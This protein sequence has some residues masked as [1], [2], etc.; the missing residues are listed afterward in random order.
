MP[1]TT[2]PAILPPSPRE[3]SE[4]WGGVGGGGRSF[5]SPVGGGGGGGGGGAEFHFTRCPPTP[6]H[7]A[8]AMFADPPHRDAG[9]GL[10]NG[11][12]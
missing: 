11:C 9:G 7:I 4:W 1:S 2:R 6:A 8:F 10:H 5:I 3:R 12:R